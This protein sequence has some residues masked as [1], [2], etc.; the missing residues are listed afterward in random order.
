LSRD[1]YDVVIV[2]AGPTG[3]CAG[4]FLQS[5]GVSVALLEREAATVVEPR[6][7]TLD[8]ESLRALATL[9]LL[10]QIE[11]LL[12]PGYG[13]RWYTGTGRELARVSANAARYGYFCRNGF[14]QPELVN[15]L[16]ATL[17]QRADVFFETTVA[18]VE[19]DADGVRVSSFDRAG[20]ERVFHARFAIAC[21]GAASPIREALGIQLAGD[22]H[23]QPWLIVDT[24]NSRETDRFSK[25]YC[26]SPR[27]YVAV[28][29][30]DGRLRYE[31][32]YL[33]GEVPENLSSSADVRGW[34][35][36]RRDL[37]DEDIVRIAVY[38]FHS[39][40]SPRWRV[41]NL[42]FAGDAAHLM[43]PFAGQGM[44]AGIR[45]AF[46]LAWKL[47]AVVGGRADDPLL[48]TYQNE[49]RPHVRSMLRLSE[50]I[51]T[52]VMSRDSVAATAR[53]VLLPAARRIPGLR[54]YI[55]EMRFK[56]KVRFGRGSAPN[57][58]VRDEHNEL[59]TFDEIAGPGFAVVAVG[60]SGTPTLPKASP[61][62]GALDARRVRLCS[63]EYIALN[64]PGW[65]TAADTHASFARELGIRA[66]AVAIVRPDRIVAEI[67][68]PHQL[69]A[70]ERRLRATLALREPG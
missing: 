45:D 23:A 63:G 16:A 64:E 38:R 53:D 51:G 11:P 12:L 25:F 20:R 50:T 46:N 35:R 1:R 7:V 9:G 18:G 21:D 56:P 27:P 58:R 36:G 6:A 2:G 49:R 55:A 67:C 37:R 44:N 39:R 60:R 3:L 66:D 61:L 34:L 59:R 48:D 4:L 22:T 5:R 47:A 40:V 8:D 19:Q 42:F 57:P 41:G 24:I 13:T 28:P 54:D 32:M 29:G 65:S 31:F 15:V 10:P 69:P 68:R 43:P 62:L 52:V 70:A 33:P 30:R 17:A 26:G 14:S